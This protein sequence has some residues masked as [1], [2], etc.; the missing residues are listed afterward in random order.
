MLG[1]QLSPTLSVNPV[2]RIKSAMS[3]RL[4]FIAFSFW[5][6]NWDR[7]QDASARQTGPGAR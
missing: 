7:T 1:K 4:K 5:R 3:L 2:D 6:R